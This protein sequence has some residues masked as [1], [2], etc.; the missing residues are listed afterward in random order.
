MQMEGGTIG[1]C[2]VGGICDY[3]YKVGISMDDGSRFDGCSTVAHELCHNCGCPHDGDPP[4]SYIGGS[5]GA[6]SCPWD[7]GYMM[8]Y[9]ERDTRQYRFSECS[10]QCVEHMFTIASCMKVRNF[11]NG[12]IDLSDSRQPGEF[13]SDQL[14]VK[15]EAPYYN[16]RCRERREDL[17]LYKVP[18]ETCSYC[19]REPTNKEGWF[20]YYIMKCLDGEPCASGTKVCENGI[21]KDRVK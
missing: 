6:E 14:G 2:Y 1:I 12:A 5:P 13:V 11:V 4:P 19:C 20:Y 10:K 16:Q 21:C 15:D 3:W 18:G 9:I 17:L 7:D 8:S